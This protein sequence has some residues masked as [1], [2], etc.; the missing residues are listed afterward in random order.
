MPYK[1]LKENNKPEFLRM[2]E[3]MIVFSMGPD[4]IEALAKECGAYSKYEDH[5]VL[6]DRGRLREY[7][8]TFR[9]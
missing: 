8:E 6:I 1:G 9:V 2:K 3:A 7:I 5:I 4:K